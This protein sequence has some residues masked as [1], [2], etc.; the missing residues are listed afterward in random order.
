MIFATTIE[1]VNSYSFWIRTYSLE[2]TVLN[3]KARRHQ[4]TKTK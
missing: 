4:Y 3:P 1:A 2:L